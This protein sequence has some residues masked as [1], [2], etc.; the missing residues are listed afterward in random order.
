[1]RGIEHVISAISNS[2]KTEI[3]NSKDPSADKC[4]IMKT[5]CRQSTGSASGEQIFLSKGR[6]QGENIYT[7]ENNLFLY[8]RNVCE[9]SVHSG[10][11]DS[12]VYSRLLVTR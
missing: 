2:T 12:S 3:N 11:C 7:R 8:N 10:I 6:T 5:D 4:P 9:R 1:M